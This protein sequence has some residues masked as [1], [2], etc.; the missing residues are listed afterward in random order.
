[1]R[2]K[3]TGADWLS[4]CDHILIRALW[5][6]IY[7]IILICL[8][9]RERMKLR[10]ALSGLRNKYL[11]KTMVKKSQAFL[12]GDV[13]EQNISQNQSLFSKMMQYCLRGVKLQHV[14]Q[15]PA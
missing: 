11:I 13:F 3:I 4:G 6:G 9:K 7:R 14:I 12:F 10:P 2:I 5:L 15:I 1:M 8:P